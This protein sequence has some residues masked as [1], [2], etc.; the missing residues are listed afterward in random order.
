[1]KNYSLAEK[2]P[3]IAAMW[4]SANN[5][6]LKPEQVSVRSNRIIS[7]LYPYNDPNTGEHY[8]YRWK[9]SI[10]NCI[11]FGCPYLA[12]KKAVLVIMSQE[13]WNLL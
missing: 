6:K 9:A 12:E 7:W 1:M 2:Y 8:D 4:D 11:R 5:G 13:D 3:E 10:P